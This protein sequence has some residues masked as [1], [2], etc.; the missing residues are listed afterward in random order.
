MT[1]DGDAPDFVGVTATDGA[2]GVGETL[3]ITV[4][5]DEVV[6]VT[7][8]P[9]LTLSNGDTA[10]YSSGTG[11]NSL[12]FTTVIAEADTASSDLSVSAYGGTITDTAGGAAGAASGDLGAVTVDGD[13]PDLSSVVDTTGDGA[14]G[15]GETISITVTWDEAVIVTGSPTLTLGNSA[16]ATYASGS[17][18]TALVFNYVVAEGNSNSADLTVTAWTGGTIKDA[19]GGTAAAT[20]TVDLGSV[21]VDGDAPDMSGVAAADDTYKIGDQI[22]IT[23][24]WDEAVIVTGSPTL[25]LSNS[26]TASYTSGSGN[27]ALVFTYT[28]AE[29]DAASNDLTVSSHSGGTIKDA[30]GGT[31]ASATGDPGTVVI[32]ADT[33]D[34]SGC[35]ATNAAYGVGEAISIT[36]T[37]DEAVT[38][39]G[40]P[41]ITLSNNDVASY[42]SGSGSTDIVFSTTVA[43]GDT[44]SADLSVS[45][46]SP[47]AGGATMKDANANAVSTVITGGDLGSVTVDGDAPDFASVAATDGA[48]GVGESL[49]ITVTW[50]EAVVVTGTPTLTLSNGDTATYA[51]GTG[52]TALVFTTTI[53]EADTDSADLSV[54][55]YGGTIA[56]AAGGAAG[57]ASGDLGAVTVDGDAPDLS[58]V[59][60]TT[61]DGAYGVG[62]TISI[63]VTWDEA[64]VVSGTPTLT[65]SNSASATYASGTGTT[66]L[67]FNYVVAEGNTASADLSVTAYGGTIT[68]AAGGCL[69]YTSPSPRDKRQSRMPSSA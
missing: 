11:T 15:V 40:T 63:T 35:D 33:P 28:V 56:D 19:A 43:E 8:T 34:M 69:L 54:S 68:D 30:A 18:S 24:T 39:T 21:T 42:A 51:S 55:A 47:T 23:V 60:D 48:Y 9:T 16:S 53:A 6:S 13:A 1:V 36:C 22:A 25:T 31:A 26:A 64:V 44:D 57:A 27:A 3:S 32:D 46:I 58:S 67:V 65:L 49:S 14:Y 59:A 10:S 5:W 50:D 38:V 61:G 20:G 7:G 17:G 4:V 41:T 45:S 29:N 52:S 37:F 2:Y 66:A 12:V 62:E